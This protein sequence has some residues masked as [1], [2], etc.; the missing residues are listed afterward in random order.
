MD[1]EVSNEEPLWRSNDT[2][3]CITGRHHDRPR[4]RAENDGHFRSIRTVL[5]T[6]MTDVLPTLKL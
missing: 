6:R 3:G 4:H 5:R 2:D 1:A